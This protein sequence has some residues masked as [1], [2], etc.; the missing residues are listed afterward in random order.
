[1][2]IPLSAGDW[3]PGTP[4]DSS[5]VEVWFLVAPMLAFHDGIHWRAADDRRRLDGIAR[6]RPRRF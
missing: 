6:W 2:S 3:R 1:M 5:V 4:G